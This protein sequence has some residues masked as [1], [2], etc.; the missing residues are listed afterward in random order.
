MTTTK[1]AEHR[2]A[3]IEEFNSVL[4]K[5]GIEKEI[6]FFIAGDPKDEKLQHHIMQIEDLMVDDRDQSEAEAESRSCP[7]CCNTKYCRL[8]CVAIA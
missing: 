1:L 7:E 8:C 6:A 3:I 4:K 5:Y 2:S